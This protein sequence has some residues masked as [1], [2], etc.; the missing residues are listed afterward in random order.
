MKN[1]YSDLIKNSAFL[2]LQQS[3]RLLFLSIL[4]D[5]QTPIIGALEYNLKLMSAKSGLDENL[6]LYGIQELSQTNFIELYDNYIFIPL[7]PAKHWSSSQK[8]LT[9]LLND[10]DTITN[11]DLQEKLLTLID[12]KENKKIEH[13]LTAHEVL[14]QWSKR[15]LTENTFSAYPNINILSEMQKIEE[16]LKAN[17][18]RIQPLPR[19]ARFINSWLARADKD[20]ADKKRVEY[21]NK[22]NRLQSPNSARRKIKG[23]TRLADEHD[24]DVELLERALFGDTD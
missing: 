13:A 6:V 18:E 21:Q 7:I 5:E 23:K 20:E 11:L 10:L 19:M 12:D 1:A 22:Q 3:T 15:Y 2:K 4:L 24:Y 14:H 16:W 17:P 9:K 8:L